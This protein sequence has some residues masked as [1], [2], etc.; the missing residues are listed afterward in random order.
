MFPEKLQDDIA[1]SKP[2]ED[3]VLV[4]VMPRVEE[5]LCVLADTAPVMIWMAGCNAVCNYFN[6]AWLEFT[7]R[8]HLA[9][10]GIGWL[11]GVHP[12][13]RQQCQQDQYITALKRHKKFSRQYRL[14]RAD[15]EYRWILDTITPRFTANG[16]FAGY[17]GYCVDITDVK[18][19]KFSL[20][21]S[22]TRLRLALDAA[23]IGVWDWNFKTKQVSCSEQVERI[24][25][26]T[27][28]Y[29]PTNYKAFLKYV[30]SHLAPSCVNT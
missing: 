16:C 19:K 23:E 10:V 9:E 12:E 29:S 18:V 22:E 25:G 11:E 7:A 8:S 26:W 13:D 27:P 4:T 28:N 2:A 6:P 3:N 21:E 20:I 5:P 15:G 24:L 1:H 30:D 14:R 17:I